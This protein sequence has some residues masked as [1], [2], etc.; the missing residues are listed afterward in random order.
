MR[1]ER[2]YA[3]LTENPNIEAL[4]SRLALTNWYQINGVDHEGASPS[5]LGMAAAWGRRTA[6]DC[7]RRPGKRMSREEPAGLPAAGYLSRQLPSPVGVLA[8]L[9]VSREGHGN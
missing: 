1:H 7:G 2:D 6:E 3:M 4:I 5:D 8:A 9:I